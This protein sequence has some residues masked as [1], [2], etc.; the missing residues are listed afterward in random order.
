MIGMIFKLIGSLALF[1]YGMKIMSE[2]IQ[3]AAGSKLQQVLNY[4]TNNRFSAVL[5]GFVITALVQSSS[6]TTVMVVSFANA[7]LLSLQQAIGV[8]MGANIGT[9]VTT[10]IVSFLGFKFKITA[11][12]LPIIGVGFPFFFSKYKNRR[13][14]GEILVGFG[15]LFLGLAF[16]KQSVPDI[17]H[18]PEVLAFL[19]NYT[20][21]GF[22]SYL[23]FVM[24]G[25]ILTVVVQSSS[26]A[27][28][29]TVTMAF[30]GWIDFPTAAAI[31][32][33]ENIGTTITAYLASIGTTT[34]A[35][36]AARAHLLFNLFGVIWMTFIFRY[37]LDFI[38][39]I[40]PWDASLQGNLPLNLSL[41]HT[42]FNLTNTT[43]FI[44]FVP[45]FTKLVERL[46]KG[47]DEKISGRY[48]L[49]YITSGVQNT[50]QFNLVTAKSEVLQMAK[51]T[52]EMFSMFLD[53]FFNPDQKKGDEVERI[54]KMED[55]TDQMQEEISKYLVLCSNESI[56]EE[57]LTNINVF[58]RITNELENIADSCLKLIILTQRKYDKK[59]KLHKKATEEIQDFADLVMDF[60]DFY[61]VNEFGHLQKRDLDIAYRLENKI[62]QSRDILKSA[63]Q[64][65]LKNGA[66]V[67]SEILFID[68]LKNFEHIGDNALNI[69]QA[70]RNMK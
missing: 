31:V 15:I 12:A 67:K 59:I 57:H 43:I 13:E 49:Q 44:G 62:N 41:F 50:P 46:V 22:A 21:L 64:D 61:Q 25:T 68:I 26:A 10:W 3:K 29:I 36:R 47:S 40:A 54:K 30:K 14:F 45:Q 37:F 32:L 8:I 63:A 24:V 33:G 51:I 19:Q 17:K 27:M 42:I 56:S 53:V 11:L 9:T 18:N 52:K 20:N 38:L 23:I 60:I 5:T 70:L 1:L 16:L 35:K 7:S 34:N 69:A 55:Y 28:A 58:M 4:I 65:R 2:G 6:A 66:E 48:E 39:H